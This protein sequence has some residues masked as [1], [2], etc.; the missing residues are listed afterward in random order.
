[1]FISFFLLL[2]GNDKSNI[3]SRIRVD[4]AEIIRLLHE[5]SAEVIQGSDIR[6]ED[7]LLEYEVSSDAKDHEVN[8]PPV[9]KLLGY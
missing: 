1:M 9:V 5:T 2:K 3:M 7:N 6:I 4:V 8:A